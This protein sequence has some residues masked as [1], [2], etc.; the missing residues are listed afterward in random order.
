L[1]SARWC[2]M[3]TGMAKPFAKLLLMLTPKR[4]WAQ[5]SLATLFVV[6]TAMCVW[7]GAVVNRADR[8]QKA[9][10]TIKAL[11]GGECHY[12][13]EFDAKGDLD[14]DAE[15]PRPEWL[16]ESLGV[17]YLASVVHADLTP[18][19]CK[20]LALKRLCN[21]PSLTSLD[22][23]GDYPLNAEEI[24]AF[25]SLTGLRELCVFN[26]SDAFLE[27]AGGLP[28]LEV[29]C[30]SGA[31]ISEDALRHIG[32][33]TK[34]Q[35]LELFYVDVGDTGLAHLA[36]LDRLTELRLWDTRITDAGLVHLRELTMLKRLD[37]GYHAIT[38]AGLMHIHG[39]TELR[40]VYVGG[41]LVTDTGVA[42]LQN[43]LPNCE[44]GKSLSGPRW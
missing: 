6:V 10:A 27:V 25:K 40:Y 22:I 41:L 5:F 16:R 3:L 20:P 11:D 36:Q 12:D 34:L 28:N 1:P 7:L 17:D 26:A 37:L 29:L 35:R 32:C 19:E 44:I 38:N 30:I 4:R 14:P 24:A 13:Y 42:Q 9:V 43:E 18:H 39:L 2:G 15:L 31:E 21:L 33:M 8:Q 23:D